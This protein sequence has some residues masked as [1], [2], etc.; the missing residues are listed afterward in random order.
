[1]AGRQAGPLVIIGGAEDKSG[2]GVIL[3]EFV[4]L[5]G[6]DAADVALMTVATSEPEAAGEQYSQL[7]ADLGVKDVRVVDVRTREDASDP[8]AIKVLEKASG[9]YFT[10]GDQLRITSLL[11]SSP[12]EECLHQR[13]AAGVVIAGTSAG[14]AVMPKVMIVKGQS[15]KS[16]AIEIVQK[17]PGLGFIDR[18]MIDMHFA[19]RG[20]IGRLLS[21]VAEHPAYLG[22]GIDEDTAIVIRGEE[23]EVVG[24]GAVTIV[25]ASNLGYTNADDHED[26]HMLALTD[27]C[28]HVLPAPYR[29]DLAARRPVIPAK[30]ALERRS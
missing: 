15:E 17:G 14:A 6:G 24:S 13:R 27:V 16:A 23:F 11:G 28:L 2:D 22:V 21:A 25:D 19:E 4:R 20:R 1:M 7:F 26:E 8:K 29:F 18:V 30:S 5:A 9:I 3:R 10:G 12:I